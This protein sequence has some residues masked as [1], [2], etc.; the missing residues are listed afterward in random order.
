[1]EEC[2]IAM[3]LSVKPTYSTSILIKMPSKLRETF[4]W[5]KPTGG[6]VESWTVLLRSAIF[7]FCTPFPGQVAYLELYVRQMMPHASAEKLLELLRAYL[8]ITFIS[9]YMK[10]PPFPPP[11]FYQSKS[12][13]ISPSVDPADASCQVVHDITVETSSPLFVSVIWHSRASVTSFFAARNLE[14]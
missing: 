10:D 6:K 14:G 1:M 7:V 5:L 8:R 2:L 9:P 12:R 11:F 3:L 4:V 13:N